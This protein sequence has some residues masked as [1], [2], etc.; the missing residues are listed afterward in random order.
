MPLLSDLPELRSLM[1]EAFGDSEQELD[2]FFSAAF[3][4][5]RCRTVK[6]GGR[7]IASLYW[8]N[9]EYRN[10]KMAYIYAVATAKQY[11]G[12]GVCRALTENTH[13]HLIEQGFAGAVLVPASIGLFDF[14]AKLGYQACCYMDVLKCSASRESVDIRHIEKDEYAAL[15]R[16]YLPEY[17]IL[18]ENENLDFLELQAELYAGDNLLLACRKEKDVLYG[19]ELLGN[20]KSVGGIVSALDCKHGSFRTPGNS[21]P[22]AAYLTFEK[23]TPA[24][25]YFGLA[26]D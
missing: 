10:R 7:I 13:S 17:G 9:C 16:S 21:L 1:R 15:R 8:F 14:Y 20:T 19:L 4:A 12:Q 3:S 11:R 5:D 6:L 22:F 23:N 18:Q 25:K 24:P 26:F 2:D